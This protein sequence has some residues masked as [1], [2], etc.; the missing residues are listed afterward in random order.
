M[1]N[2]DARVQRVNPLDDPDWDVAVAKFPGASFFH[3]AAWARVL[4][5]TYQFDPIYF[6]EKRTDGSISA[7]IPL[8]E[9]NSWL[10]GRRGISLPFTDE[11]APLGSD[12][13]RLRCVGSFR[14]SRRMVKRADGN[15][16][17]CA[18]A[19]PHWR[20]RP[21]PPITATS[22]HCAKI[23]RA[24]LPGVKARCDGQ[25]AKPS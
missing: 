16:G 7:L 22:C 10:T 12:P 19:Q 3:T 21:R 25:C 11:C 17:N 4:H 14:R 9:V 24:C 2:D 23:Q 8:M 5:D 6:V 18:A 13:T 15:T 20:P 1:V